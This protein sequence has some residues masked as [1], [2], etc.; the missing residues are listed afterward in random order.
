MVITIKN[1]GIIIRNF[2]ENNKK[3]IG[4]RED[5][6]NKLYKYDVNVIG[7]PISNEFKKIKNIIDLCDGVILSG[8]DNFTKNDFLLIDYLYKENI[9]TL[10]ICLG[11]QSMAR[12]FSE[13]EE[14]NIKNHFSND[15]YVHLIN[16]D[17]NSLLYKIIGNERILVNSR[18]KSAIIDTRLDIVARSD[19]GIIEAVEDVTKNFFLG[20][21]WHPES[22]NDLN[23]KKIFDYFINIVENI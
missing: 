13:M 21:E 4:S 23:S 16:I 2:E 12:F 11:M 6:F 7:I 22:I 1:I 19:D 15:Y 18:H 17:K 20:L 9:P 5:L 14:V 3:F 8:G 10:G